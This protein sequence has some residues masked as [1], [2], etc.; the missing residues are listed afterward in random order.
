MNIA[1]ARTIPLD[2]YL[3]SQGFK[4]AHSR[5]AGRE[6]WYSS[7][8]RQ[9]D[10]SPSFKIDTQKNLWYDHGLAKGGTI[11]DL[12][13]HLCACDVRDALRHLEKCRLYTGAEAARPALST[14]DASGSQLSFMGPSTATQTEPDKNCARPDA[15]G[16]QLA[17]EKEKTGSS[18]ALELLKSEPL[19]HPAL[20]KYLKGRGID[21]DIA[22]KFVAQIDFKAPQSTGSYFGVG[23]PAGE[24]F[25]VRN[26]LFKGFVGTG[27]SVTFHEG[28]NRKR[29]FVFEG[30]IDF[31][32][33]LTMKGLDQAEG[34]A[35]VLNSSALK[36]HAL[37]YL[38][39][40]R[41]A[42]IQLFLDND[43]S[44]DNVTAFLQGAVQGQTLTDMRQHYANHNDLN[45]WHTGRKP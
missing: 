10:K 29:L 39:D 25:E 17:G 35:L 6:L 19:Q 7:P 42:E 43:S 30:F 36:A 23:Y 14:D 8:L 13:T 18:T 15:H 38:S 5:L 31:L 4:P 40:Q 37:P 24:G 1:Q 9:G 27:K 33:Y 2:Q 45:D 20:L 21:L 11:I 34:D 3:G 12:V 44:G 41:Y 16:P 26:A 22:R 32:S 28:Q